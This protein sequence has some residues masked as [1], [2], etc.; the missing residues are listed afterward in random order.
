MSPSTRLINEP[1]IALVLAGLAAVVLGFV[2]SF[3]VLRGSDLTRL[4]V[5]LGVSLLLREL[6][7]Q[8]AEPSNRNIAAANALPATA[9]CRRTPNSPTS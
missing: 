3:L 1:V 4:M 7:K 5:T 6:A 2:T 8:D 9:F